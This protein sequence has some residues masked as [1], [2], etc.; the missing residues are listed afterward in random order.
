MHVFGNKFLQ[1]CVIL[2]HAAVTEKKEKPE[3]KI[4]FAAIFPIPAG[5]LFS[6]PKHYNIA[7]V[8]EG[9]QEL[10]LNSP[11]PTRVGVF[12]LLFLLRLSPEPRARAGFRAR[13]TSLRHYNTRSL[14]H[15][16][17]D[18]SMNCAHT[19]R[20]SCSTQLGKGTAVVVTTNACCDQLDSGCNL[21]ENDDSE[22]DLE[23]GPLVKPRYLGQP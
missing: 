11:N 16:E 21:G 6:Q 20:I 15:R 3:K 19:P 17:S 23:L 14:T 2:N 18:I 8:E 9:I 1:N 22:W 10:A 5:S 12:A 4:N 7:S 13:N